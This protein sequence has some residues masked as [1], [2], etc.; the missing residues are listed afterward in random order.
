VFFLAPGQST[1]LTATTNKDV[2]GF[3]LLVF[4]DV[5][6]A[7]LLADCVQG[8]TCSVAVR[9]TRTVEVSYVAVVTH[10]VSPYPPTPVWGKSADYTVDWYPILVEFSAPSIDRRASPA[11]AQTTPVQLTATTLDDVGPSAYYIE[12]YDATAGTMVTA[13]GSGKTCTAIVT[14]DDASTHRYVASIGTYLTTFPSK[15]VSTSSAPLYVTWASQPVQLSLTGDERRLTEDISA[16]DPI[17]PRPA[18]AFSELFWELDNRDGTI[19]S[20]TPMG[21][22]EV[23]GCVTHVPDVHHRVYS[24]AFALPTGHD[25]TSPPRDALGQSWVVNYPW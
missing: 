7:P 4:P 12:I 5:P 1:T 19:S 24:I 10:D 15:D 23:S 18:D 22:C 14:H 6:G 9:Q 16:V 13:C 11:V 8:T 17:Q 2:S 25:T 20:F 3:H 21:R